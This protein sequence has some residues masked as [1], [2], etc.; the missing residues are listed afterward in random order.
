MMD[1]K[2]STAIYVENGD[3]SGEWIESGSQGR[4]PIS[5]LGVEVQGASYSRQ[6]KGKPSIV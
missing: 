4:R 3:A 6:T 2:A 1:S 5:L